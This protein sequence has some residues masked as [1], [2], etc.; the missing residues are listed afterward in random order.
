MINVINDFFKKNRI[1]PDSKFIVAVS[2]GA[3]SIV[4][5]HVMKRMKCEILAL[6]CN[7]RL[8]GKESDT[9][10]DFVKKI[11]KEY[12][13]PLLIKKFNT[14]DY[15]KAKGISIEMA[16]RELRYAWFKEILKKRHMDYI[17]VA[18]HADDAAETL[19][20]NLCRGTGIRGLTGIKPVNDRI[21]RPLLN[22]SKNDILLYS[23]KHNIEYRT[24]STNNSLEYVRNH[25][26]HIVIPELK[27]INPALLETFSTTYEHLR[28]TEK[29]FAYGIKKLIRENVEISEDGE[30][31]ID[32][33]KTLKSPAPETFLHEFLSPMGFNKMQTAAILKTAASSPGK[34]F[35][36]GEY[37]LARGR[38]YWEIFQNNGI[39]DSPLEINAAGIYDTGK[40]RLQIEIFDRHPDFKIS[41]QTDT[42]TLDADKVK[43][44]LTIRN[45]QEGDYFCPIG[46]KF[47]KK[48]LSDFFTD[49]KFGIKQK[50]ECRILVSANRIVWVIGYRP[51][52]RFKI[53]PAT[54]KIIRIRICN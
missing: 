54:C 52:E 37:I 3:D 9:D 30:I 31:L 22:V 18:H 20:V 23:R 50:Q 15:A 10:E 36:S 1:S 28:D 5:L 13:I 38:K 35:S 41:K 40:Y 43:F 45:W 21:I 53:T 34:F 39:K 44:P 25:I 46:M 7:F 17:T 51:D 29:I 42:V 2:G 6:H 16:A 49:L 12:D 26:R 8:R 14:S 27:K 48:K 33:N 11:C 4:L 47:S 24:D 32:I 19:I